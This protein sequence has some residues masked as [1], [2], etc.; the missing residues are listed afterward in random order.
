[1]LA[2]DRLAVGVAVAELMAERHTYF[3]K[4]FAR[5]SERPNGFLRR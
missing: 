1:V 4:R 5:G 2:P 3:A